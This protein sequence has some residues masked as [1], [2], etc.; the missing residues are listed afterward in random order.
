MTKTNEENMTKTNE[1]NN[2]EGYEVAMRSFHRTISFS[3]FFFFLLLRR[4][5][6]SLLTETNNCKNPLKHKNQ[7]LLQRVTL[8]LISL[9]YIEKQAFDCR[10]VNNQTLYANQR[11]IIYNTFEPR[12]INICVDYY[13]KYMQVR[14]NHKSISLKY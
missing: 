14:V 10:V 1:E 7:Y 5:G 12:I 8:Q 13:S 6:S 2:P 3:I 4:V 9:E 11:T